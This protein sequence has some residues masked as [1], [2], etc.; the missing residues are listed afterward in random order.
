LGK[1]YTYLRSKMGHGFGG[2]AARHYHSM[3]SHHFGRNVCNCLCCFFCIGPILFLVG[4][5]MLVSSLTDYRTGHIDAYNTAI[6]LW[7]TQGVDVYSNYE[8]TRNVINISMVFD[9]FLS[10]KLPNSSAPES[11][12]WDDDDR[13]HT[14]TQFQRFG[15]G[16]TMDFTGHCSDGTPW[17]GCDVTPL[18]AFKLLVN[19]QNIYHANIPAFTRTQKHASRESNCES[20]DYWD[21]LSQTCDSYSMISS[22]CVKIQQTATGWV[23]D[24]SDGGIGCGMT[25][26]NT[27]YYERLR[28]WSYLDFPKTVYVPLSVRSVRDPRVAFY[29]EMGVGATN[30]GLT[31]GAKARTGAALLIIG[32]IILFF[33]V[34]NL[35]QVDAIG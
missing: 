18:A 30:F 1:A 16:M 4:F 21:S 31:Q 25:T 27:A 10:A 13:V 23:V 3:G 14:Y 12:L 26:W 29:S 35:L 2:H 5:G 15:T 17:W 6:E 19:G 34:R 8:N 9:N 28:I 24:D 32:G 33:S 7:T 11:Y 20:G 22:I